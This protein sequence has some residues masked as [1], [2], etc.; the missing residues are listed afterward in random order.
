MARNPTIT[1]TIKDT[2]PT[3]IAMTGNDSVLIRYYSNAYVKMIP[4]A[5]DGASIDL[6]TCVI[7]NGSEISYGTEH[8]FHQ[9][10]SDSFRCAVEDSNGNYCVYE[11]ACNMVDY[12][13]ITCNSATNRPDGGGNMTVVCYGNYFNGSFGKQQN[14]IHCTYQCVDSGGRVVSDGDMTV[15]LTDNTYIART[16]LTGLDY[17]ETY[18]FVFFA[19]DLLSSAVTVRTGVTSKPVFHWGENDVTFEVPVS[20]NK[21]VTSANGKNASVTEYGEWTPVLDGATASYSAQEGWYTKS[22][23]V[24]TIG[25]FVKAVCSPINEINSVVIIGLPYNA[26]CRASGGGICSGVIIQG[27]KNFQCFVVEASESVGII[28]TR[29]Q[30]C[31]ETDG[32]PLSTSA[33]GCRYPT[34]G[35]ITLNGTI[36]Y[37]TN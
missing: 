22:G 2:N 33:I 5:Y 11:T 32:I 29:T 15:D 30:N 12:I 14:E 21:G 18:Y 8:T 37:L 34:N 35:E 17:E 36:T 24:V 20:F 28:T 31:G 9:V 25:F 1:C 19:S 10:E 4:Q 3:T 13:R 7:R 6:D 27:V 23:N 26:S 16:Y